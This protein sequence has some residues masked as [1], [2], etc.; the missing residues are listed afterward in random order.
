MKSIKHFFLEPIK[1]KSWD[2]AKFRWAQVLHERTN[3]RFDLFYNAWCRLVRPPLLLPLSPRLNFEQ[4]DVVLKGLGR[5]GCAVLPISLTHS[6]LNEIK[7][8]A[9]STPAYSSSLDERISITEKSIPT[10]SGRYYWP[11]HELVKCPEI[12]S[13]LNDS[14]FSSIAQNYLGAEPI[15]A[16][17]TLWLDPV[18]KGYYDPHVYHYDND[19]PGFLKFF[20]YITDV[21]SDTG[22]HRYIRGSH[23]HIKPKELS[24]SKRYSDNEIIGHYGANSE[25]VFEA[26]AG[27][28]IAEDTAGFH[29]GS[30][31]KLGYRLLMQFQYSLIDIPHDED[32]CGV[33][34]P[35][36][37]DMCD[38]SLVRIARKFYKSCK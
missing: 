7:R 11:M 1:H 34:K 21:T 17:V 35:L 5:D 16:H 20:F 3:G 14:C 33:T 2:L 36:L 37:V 8:F 22:A 12:F 28:I 31:L 38:E 23:N 10:E 18:Y 4:Q 13:L 26:P 9:F 29:R 30:D 25:I 15:L 32:L 27:T 24:A 19:G 6:E